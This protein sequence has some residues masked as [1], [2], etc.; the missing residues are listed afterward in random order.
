[1]ARGGRSRPT[2]WSD[3][4]THAHQNTS[5]WAFSG[6][7]SCR[8]EAWI[9]PWAASPSNDARDTS[10]VTPAEEEGG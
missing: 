5:A 2:V 10:T 6:A 3:P 9:I 7:S 4:L 1:M 8:D